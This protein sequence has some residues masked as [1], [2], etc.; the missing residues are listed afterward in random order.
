MKIKKIALTDKSISPEGTFV[1]S[2]ELFN[3]DAPRKAIK[4]KWIEAHQLFVNNG[5]V[6]TPVMVEFKL[7]W[8]A[9]ITGSLFNNKGEC[10]SGGNA[11]DLSKMYKDDKEAEKILM[12]KPE[13]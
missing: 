13:I 6:Y 10:R 8:M 5:Y 9:T 4:T 1:C 7:Y 12:S 3:R 11:I 2:K